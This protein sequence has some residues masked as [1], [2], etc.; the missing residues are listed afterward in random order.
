MSGLSVSLEAEHGLVGLCSPSFRITCCMVIKLCMLLGG[1]IGEKTQE[2][3][4]FQRTT[5]KV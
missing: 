2:V 5:D 3:S 1:L 4:V